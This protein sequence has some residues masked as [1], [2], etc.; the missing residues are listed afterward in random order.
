MNGPRLYAIVRI[1][2]GIAALAAP[3]AVGRAIAEDT[4]DGDSA[5]P[6]AQAFMRGMADRE[7][8]MGVGILHAQRT[9]SAVSPWLWMGAFADT[10]DTAALGAAAWR[11]TTPAVGALVVGV[12]AV[13]AI[14]GAAL[15][16]TAAK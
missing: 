12:P 2:F 7:L 11:K 15:A 1:V 5:S 6:I 9:G 4:P 8:A 16:T 14:A 3:K 10:V 13:F